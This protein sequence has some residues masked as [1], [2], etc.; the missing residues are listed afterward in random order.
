M[1]YNI[2]Y[3]H[4]G[5]IFQGQYKAKHVGDDDYLRYLIQYVHL[6]PFGIEEPELM[7]SAKNEYLDKAIVYSR[8]YE[9]SSYKD[10]LGENRPQK[11]ILARIP[12]G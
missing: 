9:Y 1:Y 5:T 3:N 4:S 10:Y 12:Q 6:N 8:N 2:K 7:K 11:V